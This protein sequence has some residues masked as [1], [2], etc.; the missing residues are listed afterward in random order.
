MSWLIQVFFLLSTGFTKLSVLLFYRRVVSGT[1]SRRFELALWG[2]MAF[3]LAVT[4]TFLIL[5]CT[6]CKPLEAIWRMYDPTYMR[7]FSCFPA[8]KQKYTST[9][10]GALS[11]FTDFYSV[12]LPATLL[13]RIQINR[14]QKIGLVF[15]FSTGFL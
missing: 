7:H 9:T 13:W 5:M 2:A 8:D 3:V 6:M 15:I 1:Y 4:V 10:S 11:V 14:W 12:L